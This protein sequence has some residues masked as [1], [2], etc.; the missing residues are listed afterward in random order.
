MALNPLSLG[1]PDLALDL[2]KVAEALTAQEAL[3][4]LELQHR[5]RASKQLPD[6]RQAVICSLKEMLNKLQGPTRTLLDM[7]NT[8]RVRISVIRAMINLS[9]AT[10]VPR[11]GSISFT[12][13]AEKVKVDQVLLERLLRFAFS[14]GIFTETTAGSGEVCHTEL[15]REL[16]T[17][18]P[19]V[20]LV[21]SSTIMLPDF[22][23]SEA[24]ELGR[25]K[26]GRK[27]AAELAL[28]EDFWHA[29]ES[30]SQSVDFHD[31]MKSL[32]AAQ[33]ACVEVSVRDLFL[34]E[35]QAEAH[36]IDIGGGHGQTAIEGARRNI[37]LSFIVQ[38]TEENKV[39]AERAIPQELR[40]RVTFQ[41]HDFFT[42]QPIIPDYPLI[43]FMKWILHDWSD[44]RCIEILKHLVPLLNQ[45]GNRLLVAE[46]VLSDESYVRAMDMTML[47]MFNSG[48]RT[49]EQFDSLF[50]RVD[51]RMHIVK[52]W[53]SGEI[54]MKILEIKLIPIKRSI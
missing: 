54:G 31:G 48:E 23:L 10:I 39:A 33:R 42:P 52:I 1:T 36:V 13:L 25:L 15:S 4:E 35:Q 8:A 20:Q 17:V 29:L 27:T 26:E 11:S 30:N 44:D 45:N 28:N 43:I 9:L 14:E 7:T 18:T 21:L 16:P 38:D 47:S 34:W 24:L 6:V 12:A 46:Y 49:L 40:G 53:E 2:N 51:E 5:N 3:P 22:Y 32:S 50:H 37:N 41:S 19:W